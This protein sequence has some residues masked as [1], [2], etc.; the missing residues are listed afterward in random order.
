MIQ[1]TSTNMADR[2]NFITDNGIRGYFNCSFSTDQLLIGG[3]PQHD[4]FQY[5]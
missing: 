4:I 5:N 2:I 3:I 1:L